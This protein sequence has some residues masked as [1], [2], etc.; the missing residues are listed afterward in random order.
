MPT[1]DARLLLVDDDPTAIRV[2]SRM[3]AQYPDQRFATS[4][5]DALRLARELTPDLILL[6][7]DM[8]GMSG[9]EVCSALK[10]EPRLARV[11]V[12]F[13]TRHDSPDIEVAALERGAADF[14]SK[15]L[16]AAQ[17]CARV[18]AQLRAAALV[19]DSRREPGPPGVQVGEAHLNVPRLLIVDD[20]VSAIRV[21][22][23]TL[24]AMGD[25]HFATSGDDALQRAEALQPDL[26]LLDLH[27]PGSDGFAICAA[28]KAKLAFRHV[29]IV[30]VTRFSDPANET[31]ALELGAADF[32]AKP[33]TPAVLQARVRNLLEL[34]RRT[35]AELRAIG[36]H[37][38]RVSDAR[39]A[40]IVSAASD[41]IVCHDAE[42]KLVLI[43]AAACRMFGIEHADLIGKPAQSLLGNTRL[44]LAREGASQASPLRIVLSRHDGS[45]FVTEGVV[46]VLGE[47]SG[48]LTTLVLRDIVDR[49]RLEAAARARAEAEVASRTKTL[50]LSYIAHEMGNPLNGLLGFSHLM[51][52]DRQ[53]PLPPQQAHRLSQIT[54]SGHRLQT[55]MRDLIDLGRIETGNLQVNLQ[56]VDAGEVAQSA[57][58]AVEAQAAQSRVALQWQP[59]PG[60]APALADG[61]RLHQC[62]VN[63]LSNGIKYN[64]PG[65][66]V[67]MSLDLEAD[68]ARVI[69]AVRDDGVGM[70][71]LQR[72]HLF[73]PF[74]RLGRDSGTTPGSGLG[75]TITQR[76]VTAMHG[77]LTVESEPGIG[78]CFTISLPRERRAARP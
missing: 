65:G 9:L 37:W 73:E 6:D 27:M 68:P 71:A 28:L 75:L 76:L 51:A 20:D 62:L 4:G 11:P 74:N 42:G 15:P 7:A 40:E 55:L 64:R 61:E 53:H 72:Q 1:R 31:H 49:E 32:I 56:P 38:Q 54:R 46:S 5:A 29:P 3:L 34:K 16:V 30:F 66:R 47:G 43:N 70:D 24:A 23:H 17:L 59:A 13:A 8:P 45:A 52:T 19:E 22:R 2:M 36:E 12:I 69:L 67:E 77:Q 18:R 44:P 60:P 63:L 78:S 26:V 33:Y 58:L 50:M 48:R 35:D 39:I 21:L 57:I 41:A 10:A 25:F 14:V